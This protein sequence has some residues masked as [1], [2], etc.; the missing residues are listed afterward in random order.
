MSKLITF[1][2][3]LLLMSNSSIDTTHYRDLVDSS[4]EKQL[5]ITFVGDIMVHDT[6]YISART[7]DG[8]YDFKPWFQYVKEQF[9][10][11]DLMVG[12]LETTLTDQTNYSGYPVFRTPAQ[13]ATALKD[14]GFDIVGTANNHSLDNRLYGV[15]TTLALLKSVGIAST[16]TYRHDEPVQPLVVEKDGFKLGFIASTY[17]TNGFTAPPEYS[18]II[19]LNDVAL[20]QQQIEQLDAAEVDAIIAIVHWGSE[21]QRQANEAQIEFANQLTALGVDIIIGSHPHV[22][23][24]DGWLEVNGQR[25]YV[26]YS[27]G[28][29]VSA[30]YWRYSDTGL[31][32]SLTLQK[33]ANQPLRITEIEYDP[34][35]VDRHDENGNSSFAVIPLR[36]APQLARLSTKDQQK[37]Q[38]ALADFKSLY[39]IVDDTGF[40]QSIE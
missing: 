4:T 25:C 40:K 16:G 18:H 36:D 15:E 28:N 32:L 8:D 29:F 24:P 9:Q 1:L 14:A 6:Q 11:A 30:Q 26:A 10:S 7:T 19:N 34:F 38:E 12:N 39:Q 33:S 31:A 37:M 35:W 21:Y 20:Y 23:Q 17:G 13:L 27:L 2:L 3:T 22:I 5:T